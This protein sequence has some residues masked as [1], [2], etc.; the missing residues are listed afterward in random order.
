[1]TEQEVNT[2][3]ADVLDPELGLN[4]VELGLVYDIDIGEH[5]VAVEMTMTSAACP[6]HAHLV[7]QAEAAVRAA[8]G[9]GVPVQVT[10]VWVR[11]GCSFW[12][13][14]AGPGKTYRFCCAPGGTRRSPPAR[15]PIARPVRRSGRRISL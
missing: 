1:M 5:G 9:S 10:V 8:A 14:R 15:N 4:I 3:L 7:E 12:L 2:A 6:M 13:N 11:C